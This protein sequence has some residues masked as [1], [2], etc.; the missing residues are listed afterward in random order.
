MGAHETPTRPTGATRSRTPHD[1]ASPLIWQRT[2]T[3][4]TE[5]VFPDADGRT[6]AGTAVIGGTG[7]H[8]VHWLAALDDASGVRALTVTC[9]SS[10]SRRTL[11][12]TRE[13]DGALVFRSGDDEEPVRLEGIDVVRITDSPMFM[14]WALRRLGLTP[15][16][17]RVSATTARVLLPSL[18][19]ATG[20]S[21]YHLVSDQRLRVGG[22]EASTVLDLDGDGI[23]TYRPGRL[24]LA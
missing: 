13:E 20:T 12:M 19:V 11:S 3:V 1:P 9:E 6:A 16:A 4:G 23:V 21:T 2:D 10:Q 7:P 8:S 18:T 17:G 24:K 5:L 15:E 22:D 14:T